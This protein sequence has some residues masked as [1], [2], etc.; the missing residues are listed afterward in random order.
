MSE[1]DSEPQQ[2]WEATCSTAFTSDMLWKLDAYRA[3][4]FLIH[5]ARTDARALRK[6]GMSRNLTDQ[7]LEAAGSVS[8]NLSEGYSRPTRADRLRFLAYALGSGRECQS[9]YFAEADDLAPELV[10]NRLQLLAR[11]RSLL[12]GLTRAAR[13]KMPPGREFEP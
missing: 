13:A 7:L 4:L 12:L 6:R 9:W 8:G 2:A 1:H 5:L 11:I 3:A 10:E